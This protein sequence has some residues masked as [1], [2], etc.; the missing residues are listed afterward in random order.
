MPTSANLAIRLLLPATVLLLPIAITLW[1][2]WIVFRADESKQKIVWAGYRSFGRLTLAVTV[3][4]WWIVWDLAGRSSFVSVVLRTWPRA[5]EISS[6]ESWRFWLPPTASLGIFL[7]LCYR[8]DKTALR[9]KWTTADT[10]RQAWWRLVSFVIPLL[11]VAA[12]FGLILDKR[13]RGIAWLLVAGV[14]S[15]IGTIFLR[16]AE[17]MKFNAL[18]S[19][20]YRNRALRVARGMEVTLGKVFVVPAGKGHLTNAYGMSDAIA[21]T[22]NLG[23]YLDERQIEFV[24]AH[25]VAHVKLKHWRIHLLGAVTIFSITAISLFLLPVRAKDFRPL[26]QLVAI[27]GPLIALYYSSRRVEYSADREAI[28]FTDDSEMAVRALAK[29]HQVRE[30]PAASGAFTELFMTHPT[31][32]HRVRAVVNNGQISA[33]RLTC[34]LE[35][36][37]MTVIAVQS[38]DALQNRR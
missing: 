8:G 28:E 27:M 1:L 6:A 22:D 11:M 32:A 12:G 10:L 16:R 2:R 33:D 23:K 25:E 4:A 30:L 35:E 3:A 5:F 36:A 37:G 17:G 38:R 20:E 14:V 24:I 34:I 31:F 15:K 26:F 7:I 18:R 9:L 29:L 21:L 13:L 19:G